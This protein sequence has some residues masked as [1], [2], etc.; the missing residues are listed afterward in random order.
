MALKPAALT[1]IAQRGF[2]IH[3]GKK[4]KPSL[5]LIS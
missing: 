2:Y 1:Q 5:K 4:M 3:C